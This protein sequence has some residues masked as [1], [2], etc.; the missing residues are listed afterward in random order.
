MFCGQCGAE[1]VQEANFCSSCGCPVTSDSSLASGQHRPKE[2]FIYY[3]NGTG[4]S[5]DSKVYS[6]NGSIYPIGQI[7]SI[8]IQKNHA[9]SQ[10][11]IV[12][13]C[14]CFVCLWLYSEFGNAWFLLGW[15]MPVIDYYAFKRTRWIFLKAGGTSERLL[16]SSSS[17]ER[18]E[19]YKIK[20]AVVQAISENS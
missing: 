16:V 7:S 19:L 18:E 13:Y 20:D 10:Q 4:I 15:L 14:I 3:D 11:T 9:I 5:V 8:E 1:V 17:S 6:V 12:L 2:K